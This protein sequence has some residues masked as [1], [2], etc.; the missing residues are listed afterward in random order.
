MAALFY[1]SKMQAS[2]IPCIFT[3]WKEYVS[4]KRADRIH[5]L[6]GTGELHLQGDVLKGK[7]LNTDLSEESSSVK[8][9]NYI[10]LDSS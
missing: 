9:S 2:E 8:E 1:I 7:V 6:V 4:E 5:S 10:H 3:A